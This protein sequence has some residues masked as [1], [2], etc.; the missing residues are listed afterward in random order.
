MHIIVSG[1]RDGVPRTRVH[2]VLDGLHKGFGITHI[3]H[4]GAWGSDAHADQWADLHEV[5]T[6][7][8]TPDWDTHGKAAG[9]LR[10]REMVR[11]AN[12]EG[13]RLLL[14]FHANDSKGTRNAIAEAE[15]I[16]I[17]VMVVRV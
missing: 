13:A 2:N 14:A 10:N 7:T 16:A 8:Y 4:G 15:N 11:K 17:S 9:P 3:H 5:E 1:S 12:K 6:T